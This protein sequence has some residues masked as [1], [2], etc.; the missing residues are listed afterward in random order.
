MFRVLAISGSDLL[1]KHQGYTDTRTCDSDSSIISWRSARAE[2]FEK[3]GK[4]SDKDEI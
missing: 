3:E 2:F 1:H 4:D